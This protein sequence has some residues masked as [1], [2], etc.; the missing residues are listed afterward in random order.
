MSHSLICSFQISSYSLLWKLVIFPFQSSS[1]FFN[2]WQFYFFFFWREILAHVVSTYYVSGTILGI[3][4]YSNSSWAT[5]SCPF[6]H[7]GHFFQVDNG[8]KIDI[9]SSSLLSSANCIPSGQAVSP[10]PPSSSL[11]M[12]KWNSAFSVVHIHW[13][14]L[15][16]HSFVSIILE[17]LF[18]SFVSIPQTKRANCL[19]IERFTYKWTCTVQTCI[20]QG[21]VV[22]ESVVHTLFVTN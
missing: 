22:Q 3:Y 8:S 15:I 20:V 4:N 11:N 18:H 21:S 19:F 9:E 17:S 5:P 13:A 7:E 14:A 6:Q 12:D 16:L 2:F 10:S 1:I